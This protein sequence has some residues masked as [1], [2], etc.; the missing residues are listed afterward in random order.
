MAQTRRRRTKHR[1]NAAG[2]VEARG[3][4][5]RKPTPAEKNSKAKGGS[6]ATSRE[7]RLE[8]LNQAPTW[9]GAFNRALLA[10]ALMMALFVF[11]LRPKN[12]TS[13]VVL[14]PLVLL[15]YTPMGYYTDLFLYRR[16]QRQKTGAS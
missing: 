3:R 14:L 6:K 11:V 15:I 9:R 8:R 4:T 2:I 13:F 1:G 10:T 12:A 7:K 16:R 5:G